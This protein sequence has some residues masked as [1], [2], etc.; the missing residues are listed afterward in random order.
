M[1]YLNPDSGRIEI[2]QHMVNHHIQEL[3]RQLKDKTSNVFAWIKAWNSYAATFF[4]SNFGKP[5][6][7]LGCQHIDSMLATHQHIQREVFV[8][9]SDSSSGISPGSADD[10]VIGF[11][12]R[13][14]EQQFGLRDIPDGYFYFP[15]DLGGLEVRNPIIGLLQVHDEVSETPSNLVDD[16]LE[17]EKEAYK[18]ANTA[19]EEGTL[20]EGR[21]EMLDPG[22]KPEHPDVFFSFEEYTR[23][24]E[25]I[26]FGLGKNEL[27]EVLTKL[28]ERPYE[29]FIEMDSE[30]EVT[31]ATDRLDGLSV[32]ASDE[33]NNYWKRVAPLY[34]PAIL[35]KLGGATDCGDWT[36]AYGY[37]QPVQERQE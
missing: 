1:L 34:G 32:M 22:F 9:S 29:D 10:N 18:A 7:C 3:A 17:D 5:A 33:P 20:D 36:A 12:R 26:H 2:D 6:N 31:M 28:L 13:T 24:R 11:L 30:G 15:T 23:Y 14:I 19:F 16:L 25:Q 35:Q 21:D 37:G 27:A 4:T 8:S